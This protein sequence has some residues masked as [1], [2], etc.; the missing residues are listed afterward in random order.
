MVD[1]CAL[2]DAIDLIDVALVQ[3]D[4]DRALV[5]EVLVDRADAYPRNLS[6]AV[7][8]DGIDAFALQDSY[9][10]IKHRFDGLT[11]AA[12]LWPAPNRGSSGA[13]FHRQTLPQM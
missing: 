11:R 9:N 4:V 2:D 13:V 6:D 1:E 5:R 3:G 10:G 12:L 7:R 8:G